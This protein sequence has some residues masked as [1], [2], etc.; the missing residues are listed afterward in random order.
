MLNKG[1]ENGHPYLASGFW[2]KLSTFHHWIW[3]H[4]FVYDIYSWF[5]FILYL[6]CKGIFKNHELILNFVWFYRHWYWE[7]RWYCSFLFRWKKTVSRTTEKDWSNSYK[8]MGVFQVHS[9]D[10]GQW[11]CR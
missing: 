7:H 8:E 10:Y 6:I 11:A 5:T 4:L 3:W 1:D 2:K 9:E